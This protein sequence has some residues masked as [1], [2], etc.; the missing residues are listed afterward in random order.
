MHRAEGSPL[1]FNGSAYG[2]YALELAVDTRC[3]HHLVVPDFGEAVQI[4]FVRFMAVLVD[5]TLDRELSDAVD[6]F[7]PIHVE[8]VLS[9]WP[10]VVPYFGLPPGWR[11]LLASGY[12]DVWFVITTPLVDAITLRRRSCTASASL[13]RSP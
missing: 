2:P 9:A 6:F 11:L 10:D 5:Q 8:H 1:A 3:P 13:S 4:A 7:A 12:E